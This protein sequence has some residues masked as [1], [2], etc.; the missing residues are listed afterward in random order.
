METRSIS[1]AEKSTR[2]VS[3]GVTTN[4]S[5]N[6]EKRVM[7]PNLRLCLCIGPLAILGCL[8]MILFGL[9]VPD[10]AVVLMLILVGLATAWERPLLDRFHSGP[11]PDVVHLIWI[12]GIAAG[13]ILFIA[14]VVRLNGFR[15]A[16]PRGG[17]SQAASPPSPT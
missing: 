15:L 11:G 14:F 6:L 4:P 12:N 17:V 10:P 9:H 13:W 1:E 8:A 5:A 3:E 7:A 2:S 16:A